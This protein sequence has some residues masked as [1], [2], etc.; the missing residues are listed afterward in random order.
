MTSDSSTLSIRGLDFLYIYLSGLSL[1]LSLLRNLQR[2]E[3]DTPGPA[4]GHPTCEI[5]QHQGNSTARTDCPHYC[6]RPNDAGP[7]IKWPLRR[8]GGQCHWYTVFS[9]CVCEGSCLVSTV[10]TAHVQHSLRFHFWKW[11]SKFH[12]W[13]SMNTHSQ[14]YSH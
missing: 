14:I 5:Q 12:T 7:W 11:S 8:F 10:A 6:Q 2:D 13:V 1:C 4:K 3:G 9:V